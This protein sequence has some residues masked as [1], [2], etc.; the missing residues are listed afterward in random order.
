MH[1]N[2]YNV[3]QE[4]SESGNTKERN[5]SRGHMLLSNNRNKSSGFPYLQHSYLL[6]SGTTLLGVIIAE[7]RNP[8]CQE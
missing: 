6:H 8:A 2:T 4:K 5:S 7:A 3:V 1:E